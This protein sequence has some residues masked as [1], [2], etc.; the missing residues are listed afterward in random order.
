MVRLLAACLIALGDAKNALTFIPLGPNRRKQRW[1]LMGPWSR[2][3]T[4]LINMQRGM[5]GMFPSD[6]PSLLL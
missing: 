6:I 4:V 5:N 3:L 2:H 1:R